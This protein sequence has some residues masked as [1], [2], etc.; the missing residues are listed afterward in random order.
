MGEYKPSEHFRAEVWR[1]DI[2]KLSRPAL[3]A[4]TGYSVAH[5]QN[6]EKGKNTGTKTEIGEREMHRYKM[7]CAAVA[8]GLKFDWGAVEV[9]ARPLAEGILSSKRT[10]EKA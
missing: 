5:I 4:L 1:K 10:M 6:F 2:M 9:D 8:A 7:V 3:A